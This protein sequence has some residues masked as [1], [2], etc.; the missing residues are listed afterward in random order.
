MS[1][2]ERELLAEIAAAG[3]V[4]ISASV[5]SADE[6][7]PALLSPGGTTLG[8]LIGDDHVTPL[9]A[10]GYLRRREGM[11]RGFDVY[12]LTT[13]GWARCKD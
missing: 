12:D 8:V 3:G 13:V 6:R 4:G 1:P 11:P 7:R 10:R 2:A 9:V 5:R